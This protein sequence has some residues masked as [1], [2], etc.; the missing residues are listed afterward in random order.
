MVVFFFVFCYPFFY[1]L[2][3]NENGFPIFNFFRKKWAF[4]SSALS[5]IFYRYEFKD[6]VDWSRTYIICPNHASNLDISAI[7]IMM[8][9]NFFFLGKEELLKHPLMRIFF[10][11]VDIPVN[12]NQ[13]ISAYK[14]FLKVEQRLLSGMSVIIFPEGKI[15][16]EFP[17]LLHEFKN[18][19]FKLAIKHKIPIL[20]ISIQ[21]NWQILWD[22]GQKYGC[23]PGFSHICVHEVI[24]TK[25]FNTED[26][27]ILK[28]LVYE[29]IASELA[30]KL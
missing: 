29:K 20:P 15:G 1:F 5:G 3:K 17:P 16:N 24:E 28:Q 21:N 9:N 4:L 7:S 25:D 27:E 30:Y 10:K 19:P 18:G 6:E 22:D 12:R 23:K 14:S 11:T 2:S 8:K 26:E 13:K